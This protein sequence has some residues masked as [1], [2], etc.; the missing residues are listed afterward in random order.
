M[1]AMDRPLHTLEADEVDAYIDTAID[2]LFVPRTTDGS[3]ASGLEARNS[4]ILGGI[5]EPLQ[6]AVLSLDWEVSE[7]NIE[8][9]EERVKEL[10]ARFPNDKHVAAVAQMV[11]GVSKYLLTL[12]ETA[13]P[14]GVQFP[15][16]AVRTLEVLLSEPP[17]PPAG[18]KAAVEHLLEKYR[19]LQAEVRRNRTAAAQTQPVTTES[20]P[21]P[22][23]EVPTAAPPTVEAGDRATTPE[24]AGV[25]AATPTEPRSADSEAPPAP[26]REATEEVEELEPLE[27]EPVEEGPALVGAGA[28]EEEELPAEL[29]AE[30]HSAAEV[31]PAPTELRSQEP[32]LPAEEIEALGALDQEALS[33]AEAA[34]GTHEFHADLGSE[35]GPERTEEIEITATWETG[36]PSSFAEAEEP[37][38]EELGVQEFAEAEAD[39]GELAGPLA[40][41]EQP[42]TETAPG[43]WVERLETELAAVR[44]TLGGLVT[45]VAR[46][47]AQL[48]RLPAREESTAAGLLS[49]A[50]PRPRAEPPPERPATANSLAARRVCI[51]SVGG[52]LV[53]LPAELVAS[54]Y[55]TSAKQ[56]RKIRERGYATMG[57]FRA[58]F[59][60]IKRGLAGPL[61][62][63]GE[64]ELA[65][66]R[67]PIVTELP[68]T[69]GETVSATSPGATVLLSDGRTHAAIF[70]DSVLDLSPV[71]SA[72]HPIFDFRREPGTPRT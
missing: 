33:R 72:D 2:R 54:S 40:L 34:P 3:D 42:S 12:G 62:D 6:E 66:L 17:P 46:I 44:E 71:R 61:A 9:F 26:S 15:G 25:S 68:Q 30:E 7:R 28:D 41:E 22:A 36:G 65:D 50:D 10:A 64:A 55:P 45:A 16:A 48:A 11:A 27:P 56:A 21:A 31:E 32:E 47:E 49:A 51:A 57:D 58:P 39:A 24:A 29:G 19:R 8:A 20:V 4:G 23:A 70:T 53:G 43:L 52:T 63:W 69:S 14:L 59:R 67:F 37:V 5:I 1:E 18:R 13:S 35:A 60:N 38:G